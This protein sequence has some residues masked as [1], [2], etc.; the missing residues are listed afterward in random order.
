MKAKKRTKKRKMEHT[1]STFE[2]FLEEEQI[3]EEVDAA[4]ANRVLSWQISEALRKTKL[5][6]S[7]CKS[8]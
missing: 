3:R 2:S 7:S 5:P 6:D 1:G 8:K 4:A